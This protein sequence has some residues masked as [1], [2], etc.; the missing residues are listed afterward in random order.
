[1]SETKHM[2]ST[3]HSLIEKVIKIK[4]TIALLI[5][6]ELSNDLLIV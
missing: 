4:V 6:K 2:S 3:Y 1:M 5:F